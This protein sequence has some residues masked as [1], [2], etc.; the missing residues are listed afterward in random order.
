MKG[1]IIRKVAYRL[2]GTTRMMWGNILC[3]REGLALLLVPRTQ[4]AQPHII[5]IATENASERVFESLGEFCFNVE[6]ADLASIGQ[7][8]G[9]LGR[10]L[11]E[12]ELW[13][14]LD[15]DDFDPTKW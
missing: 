12:R 9:A 14:L 10:D 5:V 3:E 7:R 6:T 4:K 1:C 13:D 2:P 11:G 8:L 15:A